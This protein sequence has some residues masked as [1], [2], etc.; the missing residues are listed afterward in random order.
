MCTFLSPARRSAVGPALPDAK[1]GFQSRLGPGASRVPARPVWTSASASPRDAADTGRAPARR[2]LGTTDIHRGR[3]SSPDT[4]AAGPRWASR[5]LAPRGDGRLRRH[6]WIAAVERRA[7]LET[8]GGMLTRP[9][10][11]APAR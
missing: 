8:G 3:A 11:L 6:G 7:G 9:R 1:A 5:R 2:A 10:P 4:D